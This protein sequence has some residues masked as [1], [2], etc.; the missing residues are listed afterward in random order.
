MNPEPR[1]QMSPAAV[2]DRMS[3]SDS[4]FSLPHAVE[5]DVRRELLAHEEWNFHSLVVHRMKDGICLQGVI[6]SDSPETKS[7]VCDLVR[8]LTGLTSVLDQLVV[9]KQ[10]PQPAPK[11]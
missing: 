11:G 4:H 10:S 8:R 5:L 6:E 1:S 3:C 2:S 7:D 9:Q